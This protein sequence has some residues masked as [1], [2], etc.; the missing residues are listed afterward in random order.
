MYWDIFF[1]EAKRAEKSRAMQRVAL[2]LASQ[3]TRTRSI[4]TAQPAGTPH[5]FMP[6]ADARHRSYFIIDRPSSKKRSQR[7]TTISTRPH[8]RTGAPRA[9]SSVRAIRGQGMGLPILAVGT[10]W[11]LQSPPPLGANQL[12]LKSIFTAAF[13]CHLL[14]LSHR[15]VVRYL[16]T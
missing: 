1:R 9:D 10:L 16:F 3:G 13:L 11:P 8:P 2:S 12:R 7:S 5:L 14:S 15:E 6:T 4:R